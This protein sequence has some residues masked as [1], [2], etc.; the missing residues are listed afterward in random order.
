M[1]TRTASVLLLTMM[2]ASTSA[3]QGFEEGR[4]RRGLPPV[5]MEANLPYDGAFEFARIR[6]GGTLGSF[7]RV[8]G[9]EPSEGQI[10]R[11]T[12]SSLLRY[13]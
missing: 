7:R 11:A 10:R 1:S 9:P 13:A 6:F 2:L 4:G 3:A 5:A 8:D 12:V